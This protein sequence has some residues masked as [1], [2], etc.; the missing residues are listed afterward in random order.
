MFRYVIGIDGGGTKTE[1]VLLDGTGR[2]LA[3]ERDGATNPND[4]GVDVA[5]RRLAN[6]AETLVERVGVDP[7]D[8]CLFGGIAGALNHRE[9]MKQRLSR[10][11]PSLGSIDIGSDVVNLL[12]SE[13]PEG[14][15]ACIVCGTGSACFLR[16]GRELV[17]IGGWGYLLDS[18]GSGYDIGRQ[19]LE[20]ALRAYDRRGAATCLTE[21]L[22]DVLGC[23]VEQGITRIY[24]GG[25]PYIA[26]M[27]PAVFSAAAEGDEVAEAILNRNAAAIAEYIAAARRWLD[28]DREPLPVVQGTAVMQSMTVILGGGIGQHYD[29]AWADRIGRLTDPSLKASIRTAHAPA[30]WGA[31]V[32]A[33]RRSGQTPEF[34]ELYGTFM[35]GYEKE[36][37]E[38]K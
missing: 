8:C 25:K 24:D 33:Y 9:D 22:A 3:R 12:S 13:L 17:R 35:T 5:C 28:N 7:R 31:A 38:C 20:A 15:G 27:A 23:P 29:P 11:C 6:M 37:Q 34:R 36:R 19:G 30:V 2:L 18:A 10:L 21:R 1:G 32:E 16:R 4:I 26:S 14:D